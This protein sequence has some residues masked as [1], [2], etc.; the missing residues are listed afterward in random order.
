MKMWLNKK[1]TIARAEVFASMVFLCAAC[2]EGNEAAFSRVTTADSAGDVELL[3]GSYNIS[4]QTFL[5][6]APLGE[7]A[8]EIDADAAPLAAT[9]FVLHTRSGYYDGLTFHRV[10]PGFM[11]QGGDPAGTGSGGQSIFGSPFEDEANALTM[12]RGVIAMANSGAD[13]N[14]SQFFIVQA[15]AGTPHLLGRHTIFGRVT[16]GLD[17]VDAI[18]TAPASTSDR[19]LTAITM[20]LAEQ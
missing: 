3:T 13:T 11:I 7:I 17:V 14:G 18:A 5:G 15:E 6:G 12:D 1:C 19:P 16:S 2:G 20:T 10:I 8:L 9:N 4:L